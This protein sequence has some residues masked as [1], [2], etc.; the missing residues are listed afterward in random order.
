MSTETRE[1]ELWWQENGDRL[2]DCG[3]MAVAWQSWLARSKSPGAGVV[4]QHWKIERE[5]AD[6]I[7]IDADG[8][9]YYVARMEADRI[10]DI[11]LYA[12][13]ND[14]LTA[15]PTAPAE[16]GGG[17][18]AEIR[19]E[20]DPSDE[21]VSFLVLTNEDKT[22]PYLFIPEDLDDSVLDEVL[23]RLN[24]HN[25]EQAVQGDTVPIPR[26]IAHARAMAL[27][28]ME[29]LRANAPEQLITPDVEQGGEWVRCNER[30]PTEADA[31]DNGRVWVFSAESDRDDKIFVL[32]IET[33]KLHC[34]AF[35]T[36]PVT[37]WAPMQKRPKPP[38]SKEDRGHE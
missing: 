6:R 4:P 1:F 15:A 13:A 20:R 5:S 30:L 32:N 31:D 8:L 26:G 11:M 24:A 29:W 25:G 17:L 28:G 10:A 27:T 36:V 12:L 34:R 16:Q 2:R 35:G 22:E 21:Y 37:Y 38:K 23:L 33:L 19:T 14:L 7:T 18:K 9:G 3:P